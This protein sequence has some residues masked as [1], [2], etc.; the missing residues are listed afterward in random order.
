MLE[1]KDCE[2]WWKEKNI[3]SSE[4]GITVECKQPSFFSVLFRR[5]ALLRNNQTKLRILNIINI[6]L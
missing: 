3:W 2:K 1:E 4:A 6:T 5:I